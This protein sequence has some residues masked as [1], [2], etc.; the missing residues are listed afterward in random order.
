MFSLYIDG[1]LLVEK[2]KTIQ[3]EIKQFLNLQ[4][5]NISELSSA[6]DINRGIL[7]GV[8]NGNPPKVLSIKMLDTLTEYMELP[9]GYYYRIY[10][11]DC[12][13]EGAHGRRLRPFL[14][15]CAAIGRTDCVEEMLNRLADDLKQIGFIFDVGEEMYQL[16]YYESAT[17]MYKC[18]VQSE[19][20][21]QSERLGIS[22]Y[23]LFQINRSDPK[24][25]VKSAMQFIPY[26]HR[27]PEHLA[28]NGLLML[29]HY[30]FVR[31]ELEDVEKYAD[32]LRELSQAVY[33]SKTW[34]N[35]NFKPERPLVY[36]YGQSYLFKASFY[37]HTKKFE[38]SK[39]WIAGYADLSW[40]E[41]LDDKGK[42]E[43]KNLS[44]FAKANLLSIEIK[45]GNRNFVPKYV[46]LLKADKS[47]IIIGLMTLLESANKYNYYIDDVLI[48]FNS[49]IE[50]KIDYINENKRYKKEFHLFNYST[51]NQK[52]AIYFFRKKDYIQGISKLLESMEDAVKI[53]NKDSVNKAMSLFNV[54]QSYATHQ[55]VIEFNNLCRRLCKNEKEIYG[56]DFCDTF[57]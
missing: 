18:V 11:E 34:R 55:Q 21:N 33:T 30:F 28:L 46:E 51:I 44:F 32:E 24:I 37:E 23:R 2:A 1:G 7:S 4:D 39:K 19:K 45:M 26:R 53:D 36:Y 48:V 31:E 12:F 22:Y 49:Y 8:I 9:E 52:Y 35:E 54:F 43:I 20:S 25:G 57:S 17:M 15:R 3:D 47:E 40:M 27:I 41:G 10:I 50:N 14:L 16:A 5:M 13:R 56:L 29:T 6:T 38:E 42:Q